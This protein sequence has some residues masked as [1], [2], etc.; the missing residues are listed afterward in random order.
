MAFTIFFTICV[1]ALGFLIWLLI[2]LQ[3]ELHKTTSAGTHRLQVLHT[4]RM[5][6]TVLPH[7][8]PMPR[9]PEGLVHAARLGTF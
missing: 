6:P 7:L 8:I 4:K 5:A 9:R 2:A 1:A 3:S